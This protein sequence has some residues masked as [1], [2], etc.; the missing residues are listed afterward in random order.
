MFK[1]VLAL[2]GV[3]AIEGG[4]LGSC[5]EID[6]YVKNCEESLYELMGYL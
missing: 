5:T 3:N 6:G 1:Y 4:V 2:A